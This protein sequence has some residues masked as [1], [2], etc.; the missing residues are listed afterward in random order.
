MNI[1]ITGIK[2]FIGSNLYQKLQTKHTI[3]GLGSKNEENIIPRIYTLESVNLIKDNIDIII[4][5]H[6]AVSSGN[7]KIDNETLF[8]INVNVTES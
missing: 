5:C 2:G 8:K 7:I 1:L 4:C 6:A 3:I